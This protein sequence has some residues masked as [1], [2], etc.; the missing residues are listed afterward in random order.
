MVSAEVSGSFAKN[1]TCTTSSQ[2][3]YPGPRGLL[4]PQREKRE[5]SGDRKP[6][7]AGDV[8]VN[9]HHEID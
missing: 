5:R 8:N 6:L 4:L 3:M 2:I 1:G 9:Q 7:V